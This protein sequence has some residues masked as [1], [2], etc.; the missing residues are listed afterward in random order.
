MPQAGFAHQ[1]EGNL[2]LLKGG[3]RTH[4]LQRRRARRSHNKVSIE[5]ECSSLHFCRTAEKSAPEKDT[6]IPHPAVLRLHPPELRM[7]IL[8]Q[9][10]NA[11]YSLDSPASASV[12]SLATR[13]SLQVENDTSVFSKQI[14][15]EYAD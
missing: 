1:T 8:K 11:A 6:R 3:R 15:T 9:N 12:Q 13:W 10:G 7:V 5:Q 4:S 14:C 2:A